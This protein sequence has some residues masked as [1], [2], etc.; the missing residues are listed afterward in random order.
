MVVLSTKECSVVSL[1]IP[2]HNRAAFDFDRRRH[3]RF[4]SSAVKIDVSMLS[5]EER[6]SV[7][8]SCKPLNVS[9]GGMSLRTDQAFEPGQ[10][11]R[12]LIRLRE[13]LLDFVLVKA[14]VV[15]T[16]SSPDSSNRL[17]LKFVESSKGWLGSDE[18]G[19]E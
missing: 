3:T 4:D 7:L 16:W 13:P 11:Y 15:W 1:E 8:L 12:F 9:Y 2:T 10:E 18:D 19:T 17:G 5:A 6:G 14:R